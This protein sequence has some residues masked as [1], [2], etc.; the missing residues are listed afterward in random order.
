MPIFSRTVFFLSAV[1]AL[2]GSPAT[3]R[4]IKYGSEVTM[5]GRLVS[6]W[7]FGPPGFGETPK[8]D[9]KVRFVFLQLNDPVNVGPAQ[10]VP[11]DDSDIEA[12]NNVKV[13]RLW[14]M[15]NVECEAVVKHLP[16]CPVSVSGK[17]HAEVA[18]LDFLPV[19]M[20]VDEVKVEHCAK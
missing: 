4:E 14:C 19:T 12:H 20:D 6:S 11:K 13:I 15:D 16:V 9:P 7:R 10:A 18:P 1:C 3:S 5:H 8:T 2:Q 17:L